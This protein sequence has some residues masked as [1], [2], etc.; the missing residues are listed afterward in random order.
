MRFRSMD[1]VVVW[2]YEKIWSNQMKAIVMKR[3]FH[4][5][6]LHL[7]GSDLSHIV[8]HTTS[9]FLID[10]MYG[11]FNFLMF[12][13]SCCYFSLDRQNFPSMAP[14]LLPCSIVHISHHMEC[15]FM[16][17]N[18]FSKLCLISY[19]SI[20]AC[21]HTYLWPHVH[22]LPVLRCYDSCLFVFR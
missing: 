9:L 6:S 11:S 19:L 7:I 14:F 1:I 8:S 20:S 13:F 4:S 16:S 12:S 22:F 15:I 21:F 10:F 2:L 18:I 5:Y 17:K 3:L